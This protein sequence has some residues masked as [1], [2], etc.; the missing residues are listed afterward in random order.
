MTKHPFYDLAEALAG[1]FVVGMTIT[2]SWQSP[3]CWPLRF[4]SRPGRHTVV[5]GRSRRESAPITR[6]ARR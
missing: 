1:V 2:P 6:C 3:S 4:S 5:L